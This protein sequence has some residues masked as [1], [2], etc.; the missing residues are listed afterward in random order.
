MAELVREGERDRPVR[1]AGGEQRPVAPEARHGEPDRARGDAREPADLVGDPGAGPPRRPN[2]GDGRVGEVRVRG[3]E[4]DHDRRLGHPAHQPESLL[5]ARPP[6]P[7]RRDEPERVVDL[8][9]CAAHA[10]GIGARGLRGDPH[11]PRPDVPDIDLDTGHPG[12]HGVPGRRSHG[13]GVGRHGRVSS[14]ERARPRRTML[15]DP[16]RRV[17]RKRTRGLAWRA[18]ARHAH[19]EGRGTGETPRAARKGGRRGRSAARGDLCPR[20]GDGRRDWAALEREGATD[21]EQV[22][23]QGIGPALLLRS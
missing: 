1:E 14:G 7:R 2:G 17:Q 15:S 11:E 8:E 10:V 22:N 9:G 21:I 19:L 20:R 3:G 23:V 13:T 5:G 12:S 6:R 18:Y 16:G 4:R